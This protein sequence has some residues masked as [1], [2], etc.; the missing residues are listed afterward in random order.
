[1]MKIGLVHKEANARDA[2]VSLI[3]LTKAGLQICKDAQVSFEYA[4]EELLKPLDAK[5]QASFANNI[6]AI[7]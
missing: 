3:A 6:E 4:A 2:R 7:L 5:K 1:M